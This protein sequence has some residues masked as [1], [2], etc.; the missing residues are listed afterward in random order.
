MWCRSVFPLDGDSLTPP[1]HLREMST[2]DNAR[3]CAKPLSLFDWHP[4]FNSLTCDPKL[5]CGWPMNNWDAKQAALDV[6]I[7]KYDSNLVAYLESLTNGQLTELVD[8]MNRLMRVGDE[9]IRTGS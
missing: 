3:L 7:G 9:A 8:A 5:L 6:H 4:I 2:V 1:W